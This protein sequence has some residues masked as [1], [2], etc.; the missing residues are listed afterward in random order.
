MYGVKADQKVTGYEVRVETD[1]AE[2]P[3]QVFTAV[4]I[5]HML[6]G[7]AIDPAAVEEAIRLSE[8]KYCS[9]GAMVKQSAMFKTTYEIT[10]EKTEWI[11]PQVAELRAWICRPNSCWHWASGYLCGTAVAQQSVQPAPLTVQRAVVR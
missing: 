2:R 5:H 6:T 4:R 1:Q 3:P 11:K 10:E 8:E 7:F 9:V